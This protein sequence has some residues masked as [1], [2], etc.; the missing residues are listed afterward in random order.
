MLSYIPTAKSSPLGLQAT[1]VMANSKGLDW[2]RGLP[3]LSQTLYL[4]SSPPD[5]TRLFTEFQSTLSTVLSCARHVSCFAWGWRGLMMISLPQVKHTAF[6]S[7]L[8]ASEYTDD[9]SC[10]SVDLSIPLRD[11]ILTTPSSP[12]VAM[13]VPSLLHLIETTA[14]LCASTFFSMRP[15]RSTRKKVPSEHD[16]ANI[17]LCCRLLP[18]G[19]QCKSVGHAS[20]LVTVPW[21]SP[22]DV[23]LC[24]V[25]SSE[26]VYSSAPTHPQPVTYSACLNE[27]SDT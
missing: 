1:D 8:Q 4:R 9:S 11:Q 13:A 10:A 24:T 27:P 22:S 25:L 14:P 3:K 7:G 15:L 17:S 18:D 16:M 21:P 23:S 6:E 2:N 19:N 5:T 12:A 26:Q 20:R